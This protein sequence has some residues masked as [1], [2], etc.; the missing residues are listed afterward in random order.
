M[1]L[2]KCPINILKECVLCSCW[3]E[4][5]TIVN[6]ML[7]VDSIVYFFYILADFLPRCS[8]IS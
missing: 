3:V 5:F 7:L 1:D 6:S 2:G 8:I 4:C